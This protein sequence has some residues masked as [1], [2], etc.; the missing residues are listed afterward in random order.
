VT[1]AEIDTLV[2]LVERGPLWDG[3]VP[4]KVG[5]D[6]LIDAGLAVRVVVSGQDG[7]TAA[8]YRGRDAYK[9][10]FGT[11][12]GGVADTLAEA[13]ASRIARRAIRSSGRRS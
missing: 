11:A 8:T 12:L 10:H 9:E 1:G 4:S 3:D 5:R 13:K 2:A 7:Y 6:S